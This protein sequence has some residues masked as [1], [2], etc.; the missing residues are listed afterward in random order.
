VYNRFNHT[1][2]T[3][4]SLKKN[5]LAKE[6]E[7]FIYSDGS[8]IFDDKNK[9]E[10]N[11]KKISEVRN[12]IKNISGFK[13]IKIIERDKNWGLANSIIDGVTNII[14]RYGNAIILEDDMITSEYFLQYMND[15]LN[16]YKNEQEAVSIHGYIYPVKKR[17]PETFFLKGA[18]CWGWA[19]WKRGWD[20]FN[21]DAKYLLEELKS[22]KLLKEFDFNNS[23]GYSEMLRHQIEGKVD[24]WAIRWYAS[25][26]LKNKMTLYPGISFIRNIGTDA[27]GTHCSDDDKNEVSRL[28]S[29]YK[30]IKKVD[31]RENKKAKKI[32][33]VFFKK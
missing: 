30:G 6:S 22:R 14:N 8:K 19:T 31:T 20:I 5:Y 25:A 16:L 4:E 24:S 1:K 27:S 18:D 9:T 11:I 3:I 10:E 29:E 21:P 17:L 26:F 28:I 7:L 13:E 32:I 15:G 12:Y 33:S 23:Y 2:K